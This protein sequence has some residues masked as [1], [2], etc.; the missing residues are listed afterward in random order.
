MYLVSKM[1]SCTR[2]SATG[3]FLC[4]NCA[5]PYCSLECQHLDWR[6]HKRQC[7]RTEVEDPLPTPVAPGLWIS[8]VKALDNVEFMKRIDAVVTAFPLHHYGVAEDE[9]DQK[10]G[11]R[12]RL[13]VPVIDDPE[14][15]I[16]RYFEPVSQWI[17]KQ[18]RKGRNVLIHCFKGRSRSV[19]LATYYMTT[20][21][22]SQ[23]PTAAS[24]L[25]E[26]MRLR[27]TVH[28]NAG[29]VCK[30]SAI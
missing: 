29:F 18:H 21:L 8:G 15:P 12:A 23:Y 14:A 27:P 28:P 13:R 22:H 2:C 9:L 5:V 19:V 26:I 30:L 20:R 1:E 7:K 17:D 16:E 24:A 10:I 25:A 6:H 4:S 11:E 3:Q